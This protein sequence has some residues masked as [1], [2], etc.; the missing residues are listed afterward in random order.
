MNPARGVQVYLLTW[1][2]ASVDA[3]SYIGLHHV[4]TANMTGNTVLLGLSIA[5]GDL[6]AIFR[7]CTAIIGFC[8]GAFI[9]ALIVSRNREG[10]WGS[11][12]RLAFCIEAG[13]LVTFAVI[14][15]ITMTGLI[16]KPLHALI[17]VSGL[18]MGIQSAIGVHLRIRGIS[19]TYITGTMTHL[20]TRVAKHLEP[21]YRNLKNKTK[22]G[23]SKEDEQIGRLAG[24]WPVY[25]I[26][27]I[28]TGFAL[29][30]IQSYAVFIPL[31]TIFLILILFIAS[32]KDDAQA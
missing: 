26:G 27:A 5:Q 13:L 11:Y 19:T 28:V 10:V 21:H 4:F 2:A 15:V 23:E 31:L 12:V 29:V 7:S 18:T 8:V 1:T 14:W 22:S 16:E 32:H 24:V 20:M 3:I 25:V 6:A 30:N 17:A 9:A